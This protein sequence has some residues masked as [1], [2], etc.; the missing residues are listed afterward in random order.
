[1]SITKLNPNKILLAADED[2]RIINDTDY[3]LAGVAVT[4]GM[5]VEFY[6]NAS[7]INVR[8]NASATEQ[9][10]KMVA[11]NSPELNVGID[12]AYAIG[13]LVPVHPLEVGDIIYGIVPSGQNIT[14][15]GLLQS[16]G[17]GK[18]KAATA[19]TQDAGL[20]WLQALETTGAVTADTRIRAQV[21]R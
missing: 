21:I 9:C 17:D 10:A 2:A 4:P 14:M 1:M 8:P 5:L 6:D 13:D 19:T 16:N 18:L 15:G 3:C 7:A 20:G 11:V 12:T